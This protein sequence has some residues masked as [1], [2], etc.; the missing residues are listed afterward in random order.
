MRLSPGSVCW[1]VI[2][3]AAVVHVLGVLSDASVLAGQA[4][5][6]AL[7]ALAAIVLLGA[8]R[9]RLAVAG[10]IG[11]L[12]VDAVTSAADSGGP[13]YLS[14]FYAPL[15]A[16]RPYSVGD[17][18]AWLGEA[19]SAQVTQHWS[20]LLGIPLI[21][22][23]TVV[24]LADRPRT[25][26]RWL[27][28]IAWAA[29]AGVAVMLVA[30]LGGGR[31]AR[32]LVTLGVQL[33]TMVVVAAGLAVLVVAA[34]RQWRFGVPAMLGALLL[35]AAVLAADLAAAGPVR[36]V[37][38]QEL[39]LFS[40]QAVFLQAG[41]RSDVEGMTALDDLFSPGLVTEPL[42]ALV[43]VLAI[44]LL[45]LAAPA[46]DGGPSRDEPAAGM[47]GMHPGDGDD[48]RGHHDGPGQEDN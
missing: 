12:A 27:R 19:M 17:D 3:G 4:T 10:G 32:L 7:T 13:R 48:R 44:A 6:V 18:L 1:S 36:P 28:W 24:T 23:G 38:R 34:G 8:G 43:P 39:G 29:V 16:P 22:V 9:G 46:R 5:G 2:A 11:L 31:L 20:A 14:P 42:L 35:T 40:H 21:C 30:D 33:P 41:F 25:D 15:S 45:V 37:N 47:R 26:A